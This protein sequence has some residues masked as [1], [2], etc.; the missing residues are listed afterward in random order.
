MCVFI[1]T[2][3]VRN[4]DNN[5]RLD[6]QIVTL[7]TIYLNSDYLVLLQCIICLHL[8]IIYHYPPQYEITSGTRLTTRYRTHVPERLRQCPGYKERYMSGL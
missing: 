3:C 2:R 6:L 8:H 7:F 4:K 5:N 1:C